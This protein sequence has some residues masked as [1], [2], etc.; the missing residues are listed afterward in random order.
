MTDIQALAGISS[1]RMPATWWEWCLAAVPFVIG[2]TL[3]IRSNRK[4][5][6]R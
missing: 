1:G 2:A 5:R 3:I 6:G 4:D